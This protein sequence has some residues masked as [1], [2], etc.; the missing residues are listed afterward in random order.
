MDG[1]VPYVAPGNFGVEDGRHEPFLASVSTPEARE[2]I[3]LFQKEILK[4]RESLRDDFVAFS[5]QNGFTY[6]A[7]IDSIYDLCVMEYPF[8]FFQWGTNPDKIPA[9]NASD[10]VLFAHFTAVA[11]PDYFAVEGHKKYIPFYVQA[12]HELGYYGYD[13]EPLKELM[14][15]KSTENYLHN[16]FLKG[17]THPQWEKTMRWA[18]K[19]VRK[20]GNNMLFIY[21]EFDPW[22]ATA[23][24]GGKRKDQL[25]IFKQGGDHRTR[26]LNL[27]ENQREEAIKLLKSWL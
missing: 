7:G 27:P 19:K 23:F 25:I 11:S 4:R 13:T 1:T 10:S 6:K 14:V 20:K 18:D 8:S 15:M 9:P 12:A 3:V 21:G 2:K 26:I 24:E 16:Y 17:I 5:V 22:S